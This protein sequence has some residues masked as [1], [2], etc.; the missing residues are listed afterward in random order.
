M[1]GVETSDILTSMRLLAI[2]LLFAASGC[3]DSTA[4]LPGEPLAA[5]MATTSAPA[6]TTT[7]EAAGVATLPTPS[8]PPT[9]KASAV[10]TRWPQ[11]LTGYWSIGAGSLPAV[12]PVTTVRPCFSGIDTWHLYQDGAS[13]ELSRG[14]ATP[15][16]GYLPA[17][18]RV[19]FETASGTIDGATVVLSGKFGTRPVVNNQ[20][21]R[22]LAGKEQSEPVR[23]QLTHDAAKGLLKGTRNGLPFWA[24]RQVVRESPN[25]GTPLP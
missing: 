16:R 19:R 7:T 11:S 13:V 1:V 18:E 3:L 22:A 15:A 21:D 5:A 14:Y 17:W 25:C 2:A 8:P 20:R 6:P 9:G 4:D 12:A 24:V 10:P 23:Y